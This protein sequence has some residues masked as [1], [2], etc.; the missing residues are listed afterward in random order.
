[1]MSKVEQHIA[2]KRLLRLL[3]AY[4]KQ[5]IVAEWRKLESPVRE[6]RKGLY[7]SPLLANIYLNELDHLIGEKY[8]MVRYADDFVILTTSEAEAEQALATVRDWMASHQLELHP[9]KTRIVND[10]DPT[11]TDLTFSAI[12]SKRACGWY[13]RKA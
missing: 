3:E 11:R 6:R 12:P 7:L 5:D 13:A 9:D 4:V 8:R 10:T 1:M 2:D